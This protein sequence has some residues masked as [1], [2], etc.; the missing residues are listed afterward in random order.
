MRYVTRALNTLSYRVE[1]VA[2]DA[3]DEGQARSWVEAQGLTPLSIRADHRAQVVAWRR[4]RFDVPLFVQELA[5]LLTAG[6]TVV[7]AVD[8]LG[9]KA[10]EPDLTPLRLILARLN[11]GKP[12]SD[13]LQSSGGSVPPILVAAVRASET[14]GQV[15][16]ALRDYLRYDGI[17]RALIRKTVSSAI[18]PAV[19]V[20]FGV[21][22]TLLLLGYVVPRFAGLYGDNLQGASVATKALL[23]LATTLREHGVWVALGMA[24]AVTALVFSV[25]TGALWRMVFP[26]LMKIGTV[27]RLVRMF[28]LARLYRGLEFLVRGGYSVPEALNLAVPLAQQGGLGTALERARS[29]VIN[30]KLL[31]ESFAVEGLTDIVSERLLAVGERSGQLVTVLDALGTLY[32]T[33]LEDRIDRLSRIIEPLLLMLVGAIVGLIV[34]LMYM[35]VFDL[36]GTLG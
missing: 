10:R 16:Q 33:A 21:L 15:N 30:G 24:A 28:T 35:P 5:T 13:A 31:S 1:E 7:E 32:S 36:A 9:A 19:V 17:M 29:R 25:L 14:S 34:L 8:T 11:E 26:W 20:G 22:I 4:K 6:M 18:Y 27:H 3:L 2:F 12:L 23:T